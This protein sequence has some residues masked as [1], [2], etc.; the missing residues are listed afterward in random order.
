MRCLVLE[1][2]RRRYVQGLGQLANV[3]YPLA[4]LPVPA[5]QAVEERVNAEYDR[6]RREM[7][8]K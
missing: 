1:D 4:A 6:Y 3:I 7:G 2:L 8:R 5:L